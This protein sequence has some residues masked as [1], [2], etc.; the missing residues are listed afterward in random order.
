M[1][2]LYILMALITAVSVNIFIRVLHEDLDFP[3]QL[4]AMLISCVAGA[5]W[6]AVLTLFIA[7]LIVYFFIKKSNKLVERL[8]VKLEEKLEEE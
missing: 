5:M 7:G 8:R 4:M 6:P 2:I 3:E 1:I